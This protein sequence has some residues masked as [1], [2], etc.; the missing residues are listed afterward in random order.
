MLGLD[1][2]DDPVAA[3]QLWSELGLPFPSV[4]DPDAMTRAELRWI[5][6]P[7]TY[8]VDAEGVVVHRHDGA[9][10]DP[11]EWAAMAAEHLGV[12]G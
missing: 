5:G 12:G 9:V 2:A 10:T 11:D 7:V 4:T 6:L 3:A 1:V 8:F